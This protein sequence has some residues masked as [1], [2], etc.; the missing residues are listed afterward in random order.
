VF[1]LLATTGVVS[2]QSTLE[3]QQKTKVGHIQGAQQHANAQA[4]DGTP[5]TPSVIPQASTKLSDGE[6][7]RENLQI[8]RELTRYTGLLVLVGFLQALVLG[9]TLFVV[10]RQ[11]TIM[12]RQT[13]IMTTHAGHLERLAGTADTSSKA[14]AE[15]RTAIQRQAELMQKTLILEFR[16][17]VVIK[18]GYVEG[19]QNSD[20]K[21]PLGGRIE[22][23]V[24]NT[25]GTPAHIFNSEF[26]AKVIDYD[27]PT[28]NLFEGAA[29]IGEVTLQ[30][31]EGRTAEVPISL[32]LVKE[33]REQVLNQ[34][35]IQ[36]AWPKLVY[37]VGK[38]RYAD[39][40]GI[41]RS[42]GIFRKFD[43]KE[44]SFVPVKNSESEYS[45]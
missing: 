25:G 13:E 1:G 37:F 40:L 45:S 7:S 43:P 24:M 11:A 16:P 18:G 22:F 14:T 31:G 44:R 29:S 12:N 28:F 17:R 5:K 9:G 10:L 42:V 3:Q 41:K 32:D 15:M 39:E 36:S 30:S 27:I 33:L 23:V 21:E 8:Q 35:E 4:S 34:N 6:E 19:I 2:G 26:V 38:L 20:T